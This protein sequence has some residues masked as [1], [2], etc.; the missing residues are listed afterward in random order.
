V[1]LNAFADGDHLVVV[2]SYAGRDLDPD[3]VSNLRATPE[4]GVRGGSRNGRYLAREVDG[5]ERDRL[6]EL[7]TE[8][9]P[10]YTTY[11]Q[12]TERRI[13]LFTLA[14]TGAD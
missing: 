11:Q 4:V 10:L 7:V 3:W 8:A 14:P 6:W 2:G 9:F 12:R 13:P 1:V 5:S